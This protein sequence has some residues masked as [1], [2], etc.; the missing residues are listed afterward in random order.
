MKRYSKYL[1][2]KNQKFGNSRNILFGKIFFRLIE[3]NVGTKRR[4]NSRASGKERKK[5]TKGSSRRDVGVAC[6]M[7]SVVLHQFDKNDRPYRMLY[8]KLIKNLLRDYI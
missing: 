7:F 5:E 8:R 2:L 1:P 6:D 4:R 3:I